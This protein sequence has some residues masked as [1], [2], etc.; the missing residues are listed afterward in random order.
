MSVVIVTGAS[1]FIGRAVVRSLGSCGYDIVP[2]GHGDGD[3]TDVAFWKSLPP[4][5]HL[6]HLAGRSYVP[7]SWKTPAQFYATNVVGVARATEYCRRTKA[8]LLFVSSYV[9]G[10]PRYLPIDEDHPLVPG[11]PYA[12]SKVLAEQ[13]C[14]FHAEAEHLAVTIARPFNIFGPGQRTEFLIPAVIDQ[15]RRGVEIRVKDLAPRRD[16]LF[17]DDLAAGLERTLH[18][19]E[20][21]RVFN[22]GSGSSYSVQEVIDIAQAVAGTRLG[23]HCEETLRQNEIADVRANIARAR[24]RLGW[25]PCVSLRAG[26][27]SMFRLSNNECLSG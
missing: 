2:L 10:T 6:I 15:V 19:P 23:V 14:A 4:A 27:A 16:Y 17:I 26:I 8:H 5:Q 13:V 12:L 22:L 9:Y 3:V 18:S 1:G 20:G 11:S 21:L 7:D 24:N 25:N